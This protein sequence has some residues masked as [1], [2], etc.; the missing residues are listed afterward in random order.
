MIQS[1]LRAD[2]GGAEGDYR[3]APDVLFLRIQDGSAR[4]LDL[5]GNFYALSQ[6]GAQMLYEALHGNTAAVAAR[7]ATEYHAELSHVQSDL[8]AFLH[9]LEEKR[10]ISHARCSRGLFQSK[11]IFPLIMLVPLLRAI[12]A[13]PCSLQRKTWALLTLAFVAVR[14][15]GW[16]RTVAGWRYC[17]ARTQL[18][19]EYASS[20]VTTEL[21]Q[22]TKDID[23]VVRSIAA[24]HFL[25]VE[26]KERA[27]ACWWL[28]C[29]AGFPAKLVLGVHLFPLGCHC[30]CEVGRF[31]LSDDEGRCGQFTPVLSYG[32]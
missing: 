3:L 26:C 4:L 24:R 1:I 27:L 10:L 6:M 17:L 23:E 31:V 19:Q 32:G 14:L 25:H 13:F 9:D 20:N 12:S 15:F 29:S 11:R 8:Y 28:L 22:S 16:P 21:E 7:I 5:S 30:W 2:A 18:T